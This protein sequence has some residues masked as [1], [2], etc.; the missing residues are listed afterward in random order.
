MSQQSDVVAQRVNATLGH[1]NRLL[2]SRL[3]V[4]SR[5]STLRSVTALSKVSSGKFCMLNRGLAVICLWES[6]YTGSAFSRC[7]VCVSILKVQRSVVVI[8]LLPKVFYRETSVVLF[9]YNSR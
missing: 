7:I 5:F 6:L 3:N 9:L 2:M 8:G 4:D 1:M